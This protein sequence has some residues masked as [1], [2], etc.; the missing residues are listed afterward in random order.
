MFN[1][2]KKILF[3]VAKAILAFLPDS[4]FSVFVGYVQ[5][6]PFLGLINYFLPISECLA[7]FQAWTVCI[8]IFYSYQLIMRLVQMIE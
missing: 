8:A 5:N 7:I 6:M 3:V 1:E 4:P 2:L